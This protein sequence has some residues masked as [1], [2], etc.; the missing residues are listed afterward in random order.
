MIYLD[1]NAMSPL[2]ESARRV[3]LEA[4]SGTG[5]ASSVHGAG[6]RA[7]A[8]VGKAREQVARLC[9]ASTSSVVFT[10]GGS[11]ANALALRGA[12]A[13]ALEAEDRITRIFV[14][15]IEHESV[16]AHARAIAETVPGVKVRDVP[17]TK[18]GVVDAPAFRLSLMQGKGRVL[19]SVMA[20]N[21]ETGAI[22][23]IAEIARVVRSEGSEG[24]LLHVDAVQAA[25][26]IPVAFD[27]MGID[28]MTLS[29]HKLGGPQG[30]GALLVMDGAPLSPLIGGGGQE[31]GRRSGT[32]NV[33]AIAGFGA[34]AD[35]VLH[36]HE[37]ERLSRLRD[38]F[39][40]ELKHIAS[41]MI[42]ADTAKRL[43]NTSNFAIPG[44]TAETALIALDLDGI[45]VSSG[46][47]CSSGKVKASH[48]LAAMGV[49][50]D[51]ARCGLRV[52]FGWSSNEHD[53]EAIIASLRGLIARR[54][55]MAA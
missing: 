55:A 1:H 19:V 4:L 31:M 29:A 44:L 47:A 8:R 27:A 2:R 52:S 20:A 46:S 9:G 5:N 3:M 33:A 23:D 10:S 37:S 21:N 32:E 43:P 25:G 41:P 30:A 48:V 50:L 53:I 36:L 42:F 6:R 22:Q 38:T 40:A 28:Y 12:V 51:L 7:Q 15:A 11:E 39:E 34:A 49:D 17:V 35:E 26:R 14:S 45:A 18:D 16:R 54:A 13:G 24:A